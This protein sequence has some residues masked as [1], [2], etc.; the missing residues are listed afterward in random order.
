MN[1]TPVLSPWAPALGN[2]WFFTHGSAVKATDRPAMIRPQHSYPRD[3]IWEKHEAGD[4]LVLQKLPWRP[5][6]KVPKSFQAYGVN[7][8]RPHGLIP[9]KRENSVRSALSQP[10]SMV[11]SNSFSL[12]DRTIGPDW[13]SLPAAWKSI[14]TSIVPWVCHVYHLGTSINWITWIWICIYIY[15]KYSLSKLKYSTNLN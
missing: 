12:S 14:S 13:S 9:K 2:P 1:V 4:T 7:K 8:I 10:I 6:W 15:I 3:R 5:L 11:I